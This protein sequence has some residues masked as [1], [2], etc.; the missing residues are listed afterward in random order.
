MHFSDESGN[1]PDL[2]LMQAIAA[3][4]PKALEELYAR[5]GLY[6]L[7]YLIGQLEDRSLAEEVLQ[8]VM[9]AVWQGASGFRGDSRVRTWLFGMARLQGLK[10]L[11]DYREHPAIH[12]ETVSDGTDISANVEQKLRHEALADALDRL[13]FDQKQ[14]LELVFY[15]GL[16]IEEAAGQI[17][18]NANTL[19]SRLYR[20]KANLRTLLLAK[21]NGDV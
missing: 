6:L 2:P 21:E 18:V 11:R 17:N 3:G 1:D 13:P 5:H 14:A 19:K 15:R 10:A 7:N 4:D 9:L 8:A 12:E 20:A 16:K